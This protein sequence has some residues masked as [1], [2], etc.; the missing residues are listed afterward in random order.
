MLLTFVE[1]RGRGK[2]KKKNAFLETTSLTCVRLCT[3]RKL[4]PQFVS[5]ARPDEY[6]NAGGAEINERP[7][8]A[9]EYAQHLCTPYLLIFFR[10]YHL[11]IIS[12][13]W[14]FYVVYYTETCTCIITDNEYNVP[15]TE[16]VY[17]SKQWCLWSR[18]GRRSHD[19]YARQRGVIEILA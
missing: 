14:Y 6:S 19:T 13:S 12:Y 8:T 1:H 17:C 3:I 5:D 15:R 18:L 11:K 4:L 2:I 7:T 9:L 10:A 16:K